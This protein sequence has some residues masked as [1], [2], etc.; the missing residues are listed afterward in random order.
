MARRVNTGW[1]LQKYS[2]LLITIG[3]LVAVAVLCVRS[4]FDQPVSTWWLVGAGL[5]LL[6]LAG[7]WAFFRARPHFIDQKEGLVRLEDRLS[8]HNSLSAAAGGVGEWPDFPDNSSEEASAGLKWRWSAV[9]VPVALVLALVAASILV[10]IPDL[11]ARSQELPPNEPGAWQQMEDW[12]AELEEEDLIDEASLEDTQEKIDELRDQPEDDW[13]SHSSMEATD[14]L[15]ESLGRDLQEMARELAVLDRDLAA[16]QSHS[17]A[18]S[19]SA[20]QMLMEEYDEALK[21][22]GLNSMKLNKDLMKELQDLDLSQISKEQLSQM[23]REQLQQLR[24]RLKD[25]GQ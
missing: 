18:M 16:L 9:A 3:C 4:F 19:E 25:C 10:P 23:S 12:L 14:S 22:L 7:I 13:F 5:G 15:R 21:N 1:F 24:E 8:L 17:G 6:F 11:Q 20:R 2:P